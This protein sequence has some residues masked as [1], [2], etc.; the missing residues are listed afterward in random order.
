MFAEYLRKLYGNNIVVPAVNGNVLFN[1]VDIFGTGWVGSFG[2]PFGPDALQGDD[3]DIRGSF[4][5]FNS[6][7]VTS[8][9]SGSGVISAIGPNWIEC[10]D[11]KGNKNKLSLGSCS[12]V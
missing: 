11:G 6:Q 10:R 1:K 7:A 4:N 9:I 5:C 12:R 8:T 2:Y 3:F